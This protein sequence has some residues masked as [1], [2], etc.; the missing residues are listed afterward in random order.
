MEMRRHKLF[1]HR[2]DSLENIP[3]LLPFLYNAMTVD[4]S[5][6]VDT[7]HLHVASCAMFYALIRGFF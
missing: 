5:T 4:A 7:C 6:V 1:R 2:H 3:V